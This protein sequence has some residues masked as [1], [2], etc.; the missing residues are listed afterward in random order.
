MPTK[1]EEPTKKEN[2]DWGAHNKEFASKLSSE[3]FESYQDWRVVVFFY[4][5]IHYVEAYLKKEWKE[6]DDFKI[7]DHGKRR[8]LFAGTLPPNKYLKKYRNLEDAC[9]NAR[10]QC[11]NFTKEK[12]DELKKDHFEPLISY[13]QENL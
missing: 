8:R 5:V 12:A 9:Y 6:E 7:E 11:K 4:S 10:Y 2:E 3:N 1:E 13:I